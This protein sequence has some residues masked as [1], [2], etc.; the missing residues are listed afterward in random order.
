MTKLLKANFWTLVGG[1][2][3]AFAGF[4]Y[5]QQ[6]GCASGTCAIT[7]HPLNSALYGALLG[8]L[9]FDLFKK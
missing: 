1:A 4:L 3:G 9:L 7:A 5:W 2:I 6:I 8:M